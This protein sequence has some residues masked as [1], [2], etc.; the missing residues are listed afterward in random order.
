MRFK[1]LMTD[2]DTGEIVGSN[3]TQFQRNADF[4]FMKVR[5]LSNMW[6][7]SF[8]RGVN[9]GNNLHIELDCFVP[10]KEQDLFEDAF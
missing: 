4:S 6:I 1:V 2:I 8:L 10:K 5:E 7:E 3:K 9:H